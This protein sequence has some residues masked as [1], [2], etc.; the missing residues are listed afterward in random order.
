MS[1]SIFKRLLNRNV[2]SANSVT[3]KRQA[4]PLTDGEIRL[5]HSV[6]GDS[7]RL[8]DIKLKLLGG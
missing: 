2:V 3:A 5:A 7:L 4:R 6:F 8:D 1:Q